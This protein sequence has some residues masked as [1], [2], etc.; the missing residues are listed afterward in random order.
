MSKLFISHGPKDDTFARA[1]QRALAGYGVMTWVD[2]N[3]LRAGDRLEP[4][5]E[6]AIEAATAFAVVVSPTALQSE[7][8]GKE[9]Q[10]ARAVQRAR[11]GGSYPMVCIL[12]EGAQPELLAGH[13]AEAPR[14]VSVPEDAGGVDTAV[15]AILEAM[16]LR[17]PA[18]RGSFPQPKSES[19]EDLT[20]LSIDE[21]DG[22]PRASLR[23]LLVELT[24]EL[25]NQFP[26]SREESIDASVELL[27]PASR[28][29]A[30]VLCVF[31][32]GV[33]LIV[34]HKMMQWELQELDELAGELIGAGLATHNPHKHISLHPAL[35]PYLR[36]RT[37]PTESDSLEA[38]WVGAMRWYIEYLLEL[39]SQHP[40]VVAKLTLLELPNLFAMLAIVQET[41]ETAAIVALTT[42]LASLLQ[43]LDKPRLLE[44]VAQVRDS[45]GQPSP[46]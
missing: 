35:R 5:V 1:L 28:D 22:V 24:D 36:T 3:E 27:S 42:S 34:L 20:E 41:R 14:H 43:D 26:G 13:F 8:V 29:K 7:R 46:P 38:C 44:Y 18:E 17:P 19:L 9:L 39:R 40:E 15:A 37:S 32:G 25:E 33:S 45:A 23:D 31:H 16:G 30:R 12:L 11:G 4:L 6:K 21:E 10:Y 2:S